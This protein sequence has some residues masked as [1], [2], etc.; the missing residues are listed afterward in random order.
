MKDDTLLERLG[1]AGMTLTTETISG[2]EARALVEAVQ[3]LEALEPWA[4]Q[5]VGGYSG[6]P[7][8]VVRHAVAVRAA[9]ARVRGAK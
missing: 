6:P 4:N 2:H 7:N 5:V 8:S 1:L 9:L 3:A